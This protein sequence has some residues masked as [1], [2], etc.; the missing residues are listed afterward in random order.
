MDTNDLK[1]EIDHRKKMAKLEKQDE[2][3][4]KASPRAWVFLGSIVVGLLV[5]L[6]VAES[7]RRT[8]KYQA[9]ID[10]ERD[11]VTDTTLID[12][13]GNVTSSGY[14]GLMFFNH[15]GHTNQAD[16]VMHYVTVNPQ[17][18]EEIRHLKIGEKRKVSEW[19]GLVEDKYIKRYSWHELTK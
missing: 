15:T 10:A 12:I 2:Q 6:S 8:K 13:K 16:S 17:V 5:S 9:K 7:I 4:F 19:K 11:K 18:Y 14:A 1:N 3:I